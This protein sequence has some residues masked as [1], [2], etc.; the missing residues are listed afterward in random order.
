MWCNK[1]VEIIDG[2]KPCSK[3]KQDLPITDFYKCKDTS[4]GLASCC[5]ECRKKDYKNLTPEQREKYFLNRVSYYKR[6]KEKIDKRCKD[7]WNKIQESG[8]SLKREQQLA[9]IYDLTPKEVAN[10]EEESH[11][12]CFI[13]GVHKSQLKKELFIDHNHETGQI[14]GLLCS[15]CNFMLGNA[16]DNIEIL[17]KGINYLKDK[18]G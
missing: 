17:Q 15:N 16:K 18:D 3:C 2:K 4:I 6:N 13:C 8:F 7:Y 10:M 14:R 11:G 9:K 5:I 12:C 1:V